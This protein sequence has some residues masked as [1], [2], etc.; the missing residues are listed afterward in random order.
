MVD[1]QGGHAAGS[2]GFAWRVVFTGTG[3]RPPPRSAPFVLGR[4]TVMVFPGVDR[5]KK[6]EVLLVAVECQHIAGVVH[7]VV[8]SIVL[9]CINLCGVL[10]VFQQSVHPL[11]VLVNI[12]EGEMQRHAPRREMREQV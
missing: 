3:P 12:Q 4:L 9:V 11:A 7:L 2:V 10:G 1:L 5:L 8:S 6:T